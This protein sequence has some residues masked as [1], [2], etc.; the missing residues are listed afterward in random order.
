MGRGLIP[1][2]AQQINQGTPITLRP[3]EVQGIQGYLVAMGHQSGTEA[4]T[5]T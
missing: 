1:S 2:K 3:A 5:A 4:V